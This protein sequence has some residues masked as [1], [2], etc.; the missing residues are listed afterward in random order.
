MALNDF[1]GHE[2]LLVLLE[3]IRI[4]DKELGS[5]GGSSD[6]SVPAR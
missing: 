3:S 4:P 5:D 1:D 6:D 2:E